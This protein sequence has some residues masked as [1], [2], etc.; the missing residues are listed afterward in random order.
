MD[1]E[2]TS[3]ERLVQETAREFAQKELKPIAS[4]IDKNHKIPD[5]II[6]KLSE[7]GFFGVYIPE[8]YGGAGLSFLSYILVV[9]EISKVCA[10]TGVM[11][12][13]HNSLT[14]NSIYMLGTEDQRNKYLPE[15]TSGRKI[16]CFMLTEPEAGS[17]A[18]NLSTSV[19]K[20]GDFY[21]VNGNKI[22]VTNGGY[23]GYGILFATHNKSLRHRGISS[24]ILDLEAEGVNL[25]R[26]EDKMGLKGTYTSAF[27]LD[28]VRIP[29]ENMLAEEGKGFKV[30]MEL[31]DSG[32][33][34]I[35][36]QALGM[37]EGAFDS[38]FEYSKTR[39]QFGKTINSFQAI[40]FK[41]ADM[42]MRIEAARL[43]T[44]RAA[45]LKDNH[46]NPILEA[47]IAKTYASETANYV[48]KEAMQILG[49]Y[50]YIT[51][52]DIERIY[53]DARIT[54]IYEGSNEIQRVVI[55]RMLLNK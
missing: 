42:A 45:S 6:K 44:Y 20:E 19:E 35:A 55:S 41:I 51:E 34:S 23:R 11:L 47:S 8:E 21:V 28:S 10:S 7:L 22:F 2:L 46:K 48:A 53:R 17:D 18:A 4:E 38:A 43:L 27:S 50:G 29:K 5:E 54:E 25:T 15:L 1:F 33:V 39:K 9:E 12:S 14:C 26:N 24:F 36:A 31:L 49:G 3:E 13:V 40:Q 16:G 30:A 32:R 52:Y 37:A